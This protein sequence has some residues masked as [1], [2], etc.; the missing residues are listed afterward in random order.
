MWIYLLIGLLFLIL[1]LEGYFKGGLNAVITLV[2]VI[3]AINFGTSFGGLA[4]GWLADKWPVDVFPFWHRAVPTLA[5]FVTLVLLFAI[6]GFVV[7]TI[8]RKRLADRWDEFQIDSYKRMNRKFGLCTGLITA[9]VYSVMMLAIIYRL[10]NFTVPFQQTGD[11]GMLA[12]L[13]ESRVQLDDTPFLKVAAVYDTTPELHYE[14]RDALL[15]IWNDRGRTMQDLIKAYPGFYALRY[16][17]EIKTLIGD[18]E[19]ESS[20]D[21]TDN[22]YGESYGD[23]PEATDV[24]DGDGDSLYQMWKN[25]SDSLTLDQILSNSDLVAAVNN[26]Y[27]ELKTID[28]GSQEGERLSAFIKDLTDEK[29]GFLWTGKS[30]LYGRDLIVGRWEFALNASLRET[31]KNSVDIDSV[32]EM[33]GIWKRLDG[34]KGARIKIWP[35][36]DGKELRIYG[37]SMEET[38]ERTLD[39]LLKRYKEGLESG[40]IEEDDSENIYSSMSADYG[41]TGQQSDQNKALELKRANEW[42]E[43]NKPDEFWKIYAEERAKV[44]NNRLLAKGEWNGS[45]FLYN[46]NINKEKVDVARHRKGGFEVWVNLAGT[47]L[48]YKIKGENIKT[49]LA[50]DIKKPDKLKLLISSGTDTLVFTRF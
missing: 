42:Y 13:N 43:K 16:D 18:S 34:L 29:E 40:D 6:A 15:T 28:P 10:G 32:E 27:E 17:P 4:F 26:R 39:E 49:S 45:G 14:L 2:G 41:T 46:L 47:D 11:E 31:K 8:I 24:S 30:K 50:G 37:F 3:I 36:E 23:D 21:S 35:S 12:M 9:A 5:G 19:N 38:L 44:G 20:Q 33:R 48:D 25:S 22:S 7:S 1:A